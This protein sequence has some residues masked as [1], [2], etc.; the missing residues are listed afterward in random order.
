MR[1]RSEHFSPHLR[2]RLCDLAAASP[3]IIWSTVGAIGLAR[4]IGDEFSTQPF[5]P[6][7]AAEVASQIATVGV[8]GLQSGLLFVRRLPAAKHAGILPRLLAAAASNIALLILLLPRARLTLAAAIAS[9]FLVAMGMLLSILALSWLGR[10]FSIFPQAR[11][12]VTTG[13]YRVVR[14]PLYLSE[15]LVA[16]GAMWQFSQP[17]AALIVIG[18]FATQVPRM[19]FEEQILMKQFPQYTEYAMRTKWR[20]LPFAY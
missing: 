4:L 14:H 7:L 3:L 17:W 10:S 9:Y 12:L 18:A 20:L 19:R 2:A 15:F 8:L 13:P 1:I 11:R 16:L 5:S 6:R